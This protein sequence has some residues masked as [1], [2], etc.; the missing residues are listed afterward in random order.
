MQTTLAALAVIVF[1]GQLTT[2]G[3][4]ISIEGA[5]TAEKSPIPAPEL[6]RAHCDGLAEI[7]NDLA[8]VNDTSAD[9]AVVKRLDALLDRHAARHGWIGS[10][11]DVDLVP[12]ERAARCEGHLL[13][14]VASAFGERFDERTAF[15]GLELAKVLERNGRGD[16]AI[17]LLTKQL[18]LAKKLDGEAPKGSE[19]VAPSIEDE[20]AN[21]FFRAKQ[22]SLALPHFGEWHSSYDVLWPALDELH[23]RCR[24]LIELGSYDVVI[25]IATERLDSRH[26]EFADEMALV[27][28]LSGKRDAALETLAS[29]R[30]KSLGRYET[31]LDTLERCWKALHEDPAQVDVDVRT[32]TSV[33][34]AG[35]SELATELSVRG[36]PTA[37]EPYLS[38]FASTDDSPSMERLHQALMDTGEPCVNQ[39]IQTAYD[40]SDDAKLRARLDSTYGSF[41][42]AAAVRAIL[43]QR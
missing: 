15:I 6:A 13:D 7:V 10:I 4:S 26:F 42:R 36:G 29:A 5:Q 30:F 43:E 23:M 31:E 35:C 34:L 38:V 16:A 32:L 17:A 12:P 18:T 24:S 41:R 3:R 25:P 37:I 22:W 2:T 28:F 1:A 11:L 20:L 39:A 9:D 33:S 8:R 40:A 19:K 14:Q 21:A 27:Q